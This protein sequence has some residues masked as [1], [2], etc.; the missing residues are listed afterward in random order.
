LETHE[1]T[2][3]FLTLG[4]A[5][6]ETGKS[7]GTISKA[8]KSGRLS[9]IDKDSTGYKIDPAELFRVFP[10]QKKGNPLETVSMKPSGEP[11]ENIHLKHQIEL[12]KEQLRHANEKIAYTE[13]VVEY[14]KEAKTIYKRQYQ[15]LLETPMKPRGNPRVQP[16]KTQ[17]ETPR[18]P[19]RKPLYNAGRVSFWFSNLPKNKIRSYILNRYFKTIIVR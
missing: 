5:A 9:Y 14:E 4:Q 15:N 12:L 19:Q 17:M 11:P 3:L 6:K 18:K 7:K 13:K 16:Q 2:P 8:I 1:E 10:K